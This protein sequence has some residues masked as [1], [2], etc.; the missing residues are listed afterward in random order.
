MKRVIFALPAQEYGSYVDYRRL[1]E[2]SGFEW[3]WFGEIDLT[4]TD[5]V[6]IASPA[7]VS[8]WQSLMRYENSKWIAS[9]VIW[10]N[11]E[12]QWLE[13]KPVHDLKTTETHA[14]TESILQLPG[15]VAAWCSNRTLPAQD[16]RYRFVPLGSHPRLADRV[17]AARRWD[18]CHLSYIW[19]RRG[20]IHDLLSQRFRVAPVAHGQERDQIL[21]S[22]MAMWIVHQAERRVLMEPQRLAFAAAYRLPVL[23]EVIDDGH[24]LQIEPYPFQPNVDY[25]PFEYGPPKNVAD[26]IA[27]ILSEPDKLLRLGDKLFEHLAVEFNFRSCV[28][29]GVRRTFA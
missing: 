11:L 24:D 4:L 28:E 15:V 12:D 17:R 3:C 26:R 8:L 9:Q 20:P 23:T 19:G 14:T 21:S 7:N 10:W 5:T 2:L 27:A 1:I 6:Y 18:L 13:T 16:P 25:I 22:S 29:L